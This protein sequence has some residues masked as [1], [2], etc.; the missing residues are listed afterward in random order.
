MDMMDRWM[1][2]FSTDCFGSIKECKLL[3]Q[4][5][6]IIL[7]IY[8]FWNGGVVV[9]GNDIIFGYSDSDSA[10]S[11]D[12]AENITALIDVK[13]MIQM[14]GSERLSNRF[15]RVYSTIPRYNFHGQRV[16]DTSSIYIYANCSEQQKRDYVQ[17]VAM[18]ASPFLLLM[19]LK[20]V[21]LVAGAIIFIIY[22]IY[23]LVKHKRNRCS[24]NNNNNQILKRL[25]IQQEQDDSH[26]DQQFEESIIQNNNLNVYDKQTRHRIKIY[27]IIISLIFFLIMS[28]L[29]FNLLVNNDLHTSIVLS[30]QIV[31]TSLDYQVSTEQKIIKECKEI[32]IYYRL[33]L[34]VLEMFDLTMEMFNTTI[35]Y[36]DDIYRY[37]KIRY[38]FVLSSIIVLFILVS[39]GFLATLFKMKRPIIVFIIVGLT[40]SIALWIV[41][42]THT[43]LSIVISDVCPQVTNIIEARSDDYYPY[44]QYFLEC[45]NADIF[46]FIGDILSSLIVQN[47]AKLNYEIAAHFPQDHINELQQKIKELQIVKYDTDN[48]L[49]CNNT[50]GA[51]QSLKNNICTEVL[52]GTSLLTTLFFVMTILF[53]ITFIISIKIYK[54]LNKPRHTLLNQ[55]ELENELLLNNQNN[56]NN[57]DNENNNNHSPSRVGSQNT[58]NININ[59]IVDNIMNHLN[60]NSNHSSNQNSHHSSFKNEDLSMDLEQVEINNDDDDDY[61]CDNELLNPSKIRYEL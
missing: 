11:H 46:S 59:N 12:P 45:D 35:K 10:S 8:I 13:P 16:N 24:K 4:L 17:S 23:Q 53:C 2:G 30:N 18:T 47:Q 15:Y 44:V 1:D 41:P 55:D 52:N 29:F 14:I 56:Q 49:N 19:V 60:S 38:H 37:E 33:P 61:D 5:L 6:L 21:S 32:G 22:S 25:S 31:T 34:E 42:S 48:I 20:I 27:F 28:L 51:Y 36:Q 40:F 43:P 58:I 39:F 57:E 3:H 26:L 54:L 9:V 50:S 7:C